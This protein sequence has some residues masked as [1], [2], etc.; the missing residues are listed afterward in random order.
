MNISGGCDE[1]EFDVKVSE[2]KTRVTEKLC[3][4][5]TSGKMRSMTAIV[6][7]SVQ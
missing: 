3:E 4:L 2:L 5:K 1:N 7:E 6:K